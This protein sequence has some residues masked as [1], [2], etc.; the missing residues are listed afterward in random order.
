MDDEACAIVLDPP[1]KHT[2]DEKIFRA[3]QGCPVDAVVVHDRTTGKQLWP[4]E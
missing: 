3:A 2:P 4:E 1:L